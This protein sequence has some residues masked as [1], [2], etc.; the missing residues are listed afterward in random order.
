MIS[1]IELYPE[2]V[3]GGRIDYDPA[4]QPS[5]VGGIEYACTKVISAV[6]GELLGSLGYLEDLRAQGFNTLEEAVKNTR[7]LPGDKR[8][9]LQNGLRKDERVL[10]S[11]AKLM[12]AK[13]P[14]VLKVY[15]IE[16]LLGM[17]GLPDWNDADKTVMKGS[18][19]SGGRLVIKGLG[20]EHSYVV[21]LTRNK[22]FN[23]KF[24]RLIDSPSISGVIFSIKG[25]EFPI[26]YRGGLNLP[27]TGM[28]TP[29]GSV[30]IPENTKD[31]VFWSF[32]NE[33]Q[34]ELGLVK[35]DIL[36]PAIVGRIF[37][38]YVGGNSLFIF[39]GPT[40]W[41]KED[42]VKKWEDAKDRYEHKKLLWIKLSPNYIWRTL[43]DHDLPYDKKNLPEVPDE[44]L[45]FLYPL[46][47]TLT[48]IGKVGSPDF[49][50]RIKHNM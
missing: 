46:K 35:N 50:Y 7:K 11:L 12:E 25:V 2:A 5:G 21:Q 6:V 36:G 19:Y 30:A 33:A 31:P 44:K 26:G 17:V 41:S 47:Q 4:P 37:D 40:L 10:G 22:E 27:N 20:Y 18:Y 38:P 45:P 49:Q 15:Q 39:L 34:N 43:S 9:E 23:E 28:T 48:L 3:R 13:Y 16:D 24:P 42:M 29:A 8:K 32:F 1:E 14:S